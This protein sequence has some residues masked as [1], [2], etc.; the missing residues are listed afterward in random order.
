MIL[1][2]FAISQKF[3]GNKKLR[4]VVSCWLIFN[5]VSFFIS[6]SMV[7][8]FSIIS[9]FFMGILY[10]TQKEDPDEQKKALENKGDGDVP[11]LENEAEG[12]SA[13]AEN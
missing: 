8:N 5:I 1:L 10:L 13:E 11:E 9:S 6:D 3:T 2:F 7:S 4:M 12:E